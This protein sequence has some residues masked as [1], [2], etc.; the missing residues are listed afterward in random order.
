METCNK[1]WKHEH[2]FEFG[3]EILK[4]ED[5]LKLPNIIWY[6][7][8]KKTKREEKG[9]E[10]WNKETEKRRKKKKKTG[11]RTKKN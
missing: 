10:K 6:V 7:N 9:I 3:E 2:F 11:K 8:K 5:F 4:L 1:I